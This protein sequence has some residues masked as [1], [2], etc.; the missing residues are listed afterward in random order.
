MCQE[1]HN[2][3]ITLLGDMREDFGEMKGDIKGLRG[4]V[5]RMNGTQGTHTEE[6]EELKNFRSRI[7]GGS[8]VLGALFTITTVIVGFVISLRG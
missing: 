2:K 3:I 7:K 6:I 4:E 5:E 8:I 1:G